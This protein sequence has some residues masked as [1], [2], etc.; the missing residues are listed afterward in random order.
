MKQCHSY[1]LSLLLVPVEVL[2]YVKRILSLLNFLQTE[3]LFFFLQIEISQDA[4][5]THNGFSLGLFILQQNLHCWQLKVRENIK[6]SFKNSLSRSFID[7]RKFFFEHFGIDNIL[8]GSF[9]HLTFLFDFL[10][11]NNSLDLLMT[12]VFCLLS[13]IGRKSA[14]EL[15]CGL[16]QNLCSSDN[17]KTCQES[18]IIT[19]QILN[20]RL[21]G[22]LGI[23]GIIGVVCAVGVIVVVRLVLPVEGVVLLTDEVHQL[24]LLEIFGKTVERFLINTSIA[25]ESLRQTK[26]S[27]NFTISNGR[28]RNL[29]DNW[30]L[31]NGLLRLILLS[32]L[33]SNWIHNWLN[34]RS[35]I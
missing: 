8:F 35:I 9:S 10:F 34:K 22:V 28:L 2:C 20:L 21:S 13:D 6:D 11:Y 25:Q 24:F 15:R 30:S 5:N 12:I 14:E 31:L 17:I 1:F 27:Q 32:W 26:N 19:L 7:S 3:H 16:N 4:D 33:L 18:Y 29:W 23:I